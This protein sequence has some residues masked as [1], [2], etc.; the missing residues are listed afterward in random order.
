ME[1]CETRSENQPDPGTFNPLSNTRVKCTSPANTAFKPGLQQNV[2][3]LDWLRI[4]Y[5]FAVPEYEDYNGK[6]FTIGNEYLV[7]EIRQMGGTY[8]YRGLLYHKDGYEVATVTFGT[9][10]D[11]TDDNLF[12]VKFNNELLYS[13][14]KEHIYK[15]NNLMSFKNI[16]R[17]DIALDT[18][19]PVRKIFSKL[20]LSDNTHELYDKRKGISG[21]N[22]CSDTDTWGTIYIGSSK[23]IKSVAI[24][25]KKAELEKS[26]KQYI[27]RNYAQAGNGE[28]VDRVEIRLKS[29][30]LKK[31]DKIDDLALTN[32]EKIKQLFV[33]TMDTYL[34][35]KER[36]NDTNNRRW[37]TLELIDLD[38]ITSKKLEK[39]EAPKSNDTY[40]A[41]IL[42][43]KLY[44]DG[45]QET[46]N[47]SPANM[48]LIWDYVFKYSLGDWFQRLVER[49]RKKQKYKTTDKTTKN[50]KRKVYHE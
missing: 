7:T 50:Q 24:Y 11:H 39:A 36:S 43:K 14:Y 47:G 12:S 16:G 13:N 23:S 29:K 46:E 27:A 2:L 1:N 3:S 45:L 17:L 41:K 33:S 32:D 35:L 5:V 22:Y 26:N 42:I 28:L 40:K 34:D 10:A 19:V 25:D 31:Y 9:I 44:L 30:A 20:V 49:E 38:T 37:K 21:E 15:L 6:E 4:I 48:E 18:N 8:K